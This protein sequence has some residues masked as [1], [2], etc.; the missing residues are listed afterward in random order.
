MINPLTPTS[1]PACQQ[2]LLAP[3]EISCRALCEEQGRR[4]R[5]L[6]CPS[7]NLVIAPENTY[8]FQSE[9]DFQQDNRPNEHRGRI[10]THQWPGREFAMGCM[11]KEILERSG[12]PCSNILIYGAGL[13]TDHERLA[14][15]FSEIQVK[16]TDLQNF[17]NASNFVEPESGERFDLVIACEVI[18][19]FT[20]I[21]NDFVKLLSRV[22]PSGLGIMS[23]NVS[24]DSDIA[25]MQYPFFPGHTAYYSGRSLIS[26]AKGM[27]DHLHVDFRVPLA[28]LAQLGPRK[29]YVLMYRN[30]LIEE[31]IAD[32]FSRH[33][34]APSED[35]QLPSLIDRFIRAIRR[36]PQRFART[37]LKRK[38]A[39]Q[40]VG[41]L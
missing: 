41:P 40:T 8:D 32:Y 36:I 37:S 27:H 26:I 1:C 25:E 3:E 28:S 38:E 30:H 31:G 10:G 18:E 34:M 21:P 14:E 15:T 16:I 6:R 2:K 9:G 39:N 7:C 29:R 35:A 5:F 24:D 33:H 23:T 19:H 13:S 4:V 22:Q 20:D 17:Q 12:L 11:G